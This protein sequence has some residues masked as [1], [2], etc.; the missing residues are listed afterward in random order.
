MKISIDIGNDDDSVA[1]IFSDKMREIHLATLQ[2][3]LLNHH[4]FFRLSY[5]RQQLY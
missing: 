3:T 1:S 2:Q 4:P 5:F